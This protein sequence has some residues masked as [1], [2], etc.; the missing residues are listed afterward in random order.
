MAHTVIIQSLQY[1]PIDRAT[2]TGTIDG[3][4]VTVTTWQSAI[5]ALPSTIAVQ[6]FLGNMMIN[7]ISS[8]IVP[9][10]AVTYNGTITI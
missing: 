2:V 3:I 8:L 5:A 7:S 1:T 6:T 9:T 10:N 4:P